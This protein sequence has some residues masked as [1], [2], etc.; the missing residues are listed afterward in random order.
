MGLRHVV[1]LLG[2]LGFGAACAPASPPATPP[3]PAAAPVADAPPGPPP[4]S[5]PANV[6]CRAKV[7]VCAEYQGVP[8]DLAVNLRAKCAA[9][10]GEVMDACPADKVVGTCTASRPTMTVRQHVY[11]AKTGRETRGLVFDSKRACESKGG[12][13]TAP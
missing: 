10:G 4:S 9:E 5:P 13:F 2:F 8:A 7:Q 6:A 11:R 3:P 1:G 12:T